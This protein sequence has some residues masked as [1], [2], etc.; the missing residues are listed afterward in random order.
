MYAAAVAILLNE[1]VMTSIKI[2]NSNL[3]SPFDLKY[4][5]NPNNGLIFVLNLSVFPFVIL[6]GVS[7]AFN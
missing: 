6:A 1:D 7:H 3:G 5:Y 2:T 4:V